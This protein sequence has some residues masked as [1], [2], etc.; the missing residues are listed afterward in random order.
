MR[1]G[2]VGGG[3]KVMN[4]GKDLMGIWQEF[5]TFVYIAKWIT[6]LTDGPI[7]FLVGRLKHRRQ[8]N[9]I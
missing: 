3:M 7:G 8:K 6:I 5:I 2:V 1:K 9:E 4:V